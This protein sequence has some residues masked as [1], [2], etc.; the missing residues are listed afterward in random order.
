MDILT[1]S[2]RETALEVI[3]QYQGVDP[4]EALRLIEAKARDVPLESQWHGA[5]VG[6]RFNAYRAAHAICGSLGTPY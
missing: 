1:I 5:L 6:V 4:K 3:S 2:E